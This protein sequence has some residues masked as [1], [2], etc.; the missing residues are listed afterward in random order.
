V[1]LWA[2][3]IVLLALVALA[4]SVYYAMYRHWNSKDFS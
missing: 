1:S 4:G 2:L 3:A